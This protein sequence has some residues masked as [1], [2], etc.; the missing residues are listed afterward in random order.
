VTIAHLEASRSTE[1]GVLR[2]PAR[3]LSCEVIISDEDA[4]PR[5]PPRAAV[6]EVWSVGQASWAMDIE[7]R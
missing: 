2:G 3:G 4:L 1:H 5:R 6:V 7:D